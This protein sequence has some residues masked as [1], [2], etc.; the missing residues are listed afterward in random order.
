MKNVN[1]ASMVNQGEV[2]LRCGDLI[3]S[4]YA[5]FSEIT[6]SPDIT[7]SEGKPILLKYIKTQIEIWKEYEENILKQAKNK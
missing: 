6:E 4:L 1:I 5:D 2:Y 3:K 7:E